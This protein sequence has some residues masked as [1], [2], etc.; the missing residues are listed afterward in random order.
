MIRPAGDLPPPRLLH[1]EALYLPAASVI[2]PL[3]S[4]S[5]RV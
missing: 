2:R 1:A 3:A 4:M 5:L